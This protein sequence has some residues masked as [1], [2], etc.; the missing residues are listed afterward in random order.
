MEIGKRREIVRPI[1]SRIRIGEPS[2][3]RHEKAKSNSSLSRR[4]NRRHK[5]R[6]SAYRST[7]ENEETGR[8]GWLHKSTMMSKLQ[9]T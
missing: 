3:K 9:P 8:K 1:V 4:R 2:S 5:K 7:V 6:D